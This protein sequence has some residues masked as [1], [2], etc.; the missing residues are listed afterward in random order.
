[1]YIYV[2]G[3]SRIE[4]ILNPVYSDSFEFPG[5]YLYQ[6]YIYCN[7]DIIFIVIQNKRT[8]GTVQ[9]LG[10]VSFKLR[11]RVTRKFFNPSHVRKEICVGF[12][13]LHLRIY[14]RKK[15]TNYD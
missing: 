5:L 9:N 12:S 2:A 13:F 10:I 15:V 6:V 1:M 4:P 7:K 3:L 8:V 14:I 11:H